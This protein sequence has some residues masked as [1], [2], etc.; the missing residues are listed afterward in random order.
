MEGLGCH[1]WDCKRFL[2]RVG[3]LLPGT[4]QPTEPA[5]GMASGKRP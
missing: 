1:G 3:A 2:I 5:P 4:L